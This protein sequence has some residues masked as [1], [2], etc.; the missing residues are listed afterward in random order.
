MVKY[1]QRGEKLALEF[2]EESLNSLRKLWEVV[3]ND[4]GSRYDC[5]DQNY[6]ITFSKLRKHVPARLYFF[7]EHIQRMGNYASHFQEDGVE[8]SVED[9]QYCVFAGKEIYQ[10]AYPEEFESQ[11]EKP[12]VFFE[13]IFEA[14]PCTICGSKIGERC[15]SISNLKEGE[16]HTHEQRSKDYNQYRRDI[17]KNYGT[18]I[19]DAMHELVDDLGIKKG[20]LIAPQKIRDWFS[21]KYPAYTINSINTH[22]IMMTTNLKARYRYSETKNDDEKY[23]LFFEEKR[24]F[25]LYD[26][27]NDPPPLSFG[28]PLL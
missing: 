16:N 21:E 13:N 20:Q 27:E 14:V 5:K 22:S 2:P 7:L 25:R 23:N 28:K 8:P 24:K 11:S 10:W 26:Y 4:L 3:L 19:A 6:N 9:A 1:I 12:L 17:Q 15:V 18:T